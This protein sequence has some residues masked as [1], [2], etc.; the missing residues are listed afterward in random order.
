MQK[1]KKL[2]MVKDE[3]DVRRGELPFVR[4]LARSFDRLLSWSK[5]NDNGGKKVKKRGRRSKNKE[6]AK[7]KF[8]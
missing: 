5:E 2:V 6:R 7:R 4:S 3:H 8:L 1:G